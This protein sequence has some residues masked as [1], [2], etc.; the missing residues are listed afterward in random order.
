MPQLSIEEAFSRRLQS[1]HVSSEEVGKEVS[2]E[3]I[4]VVCIDPGIHNMGVAYLSIALGTGA[5][6]CSRAVRE[7]ITTFDCGRGGCPLG[8]SATMVDWVD[9]F[10]HRHS[11]ALGEAD[12][13]IIERQPPHGFRCCEQL[14]FKAVRGKAR[15]LHP[16]SLHACFCV[17][18]LDYDQRK[19]RMVQI[20]RE[21]F[22]G[23]EMVA[24]ALAAPRAHDIADA[25]LMGL[26]FARSEEVL[27]RRES[28]RLTNH[29]G[30]T[31]PHPH[32]EQFLCPR[33]VRLPKAAS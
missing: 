25:M 8:H 26:H 20:A 4:R 5:V 23:N 10:L 19:A 18:S 29:P 28:W 22:G 24:E 1:D 27:L 12:V 16:A 6:V 15:L 14:L 13:V 17:R 2:K 33:Q 11:V 21:H 7:D 31:L 30:I 9:H 32:F 3:S